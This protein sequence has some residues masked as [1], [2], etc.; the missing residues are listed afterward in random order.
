M[1]EL[2]AFAATSGLVAMLYSPEIQMYLDSGKLS[3][4]IPQETKREEGTSSG[5]ARKTNLDIGSLT[6]ADGALVAGGTTGLLLL[7]IPRFRL[8]A[9]ATLLSSFLLAQTRDNA[10]LITVTSGGLA[11]FATDPVATSAAFANFLG[12][13]ASATVKSTAAAIELSTTIVGVL[14]TVS[15][16]VVAYLL[17][18]K[19]KGKGRT[20]KNRKIG[21]N[22]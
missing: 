19:G 14:L 21:N 10:K 7:A 15:G 11:L 8:A 1:V 13:A 3:D 5:L 20:E 16:G 6:A 9:A 12:S 2:L 17:A 18:P 22:V 4:I